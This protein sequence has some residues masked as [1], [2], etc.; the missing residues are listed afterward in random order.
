MRFHKFVHG[1]SLP[2]HPSEL[3]DSKQMTESPGTIAIQCA[4][5]HLLLTALSKWAD[6]A[7]GFSEVSETSSVLEVSSVVEL[8]PY[9]QEALVFPSLQKITEH[10]SP[11][12]YL[13]INI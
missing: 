2:K 5:G 3:R 13:L 8:V 1:L 4:R 9:M 6:L 12:S 11:F 10:A 7:I